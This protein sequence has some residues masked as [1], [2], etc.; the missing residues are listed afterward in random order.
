MNSSTLSSQILFTNLLPPEIS[1]A[2][3]DQNWRWVTV[4][5][6]NALGMLSRRHFPVNS[7]DVV[8]IPSIVFGQSPAQSVELH[9]KN[10]V[11]KEIN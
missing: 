11:E 4:E 2:Y 7:A 1:Y 5:I 6:W 3:V 9:L 10:N 8:Q